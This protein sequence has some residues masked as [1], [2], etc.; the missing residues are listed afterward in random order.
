MAQEMHGSNASM[1]DLTVTHFLQFSFSF[2][3]N[4]NAVSK[5]R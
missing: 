4:K 2:E 5:L 1:Y 3:S